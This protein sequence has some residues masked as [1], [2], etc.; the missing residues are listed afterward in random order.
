MDLVNPVS[1]LIASSRFLTKA[2][3]LA[4]NNVRLGYNLPSS[5]TKRFG[6]QGGSFYVSGDNLWL[7]SAR[8]GFNP[9]T[10]ETGGSSMYTYSPLS[11]ITAGLKIKF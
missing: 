8:T 5:I 7:G 9:T 1:R 4:L 6:I 3:Y 2:D 10:S 11:T